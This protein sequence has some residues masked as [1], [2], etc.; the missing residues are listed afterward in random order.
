MSVWYDARQC[1]FISMAGYF[2]DFALKVRPTADSLNSIADTADFFVSVPAVK[3]YTDKAK[4][5]A[6]VTPPPSTGTITMLFLNKT[7]NIPQDSLTSYPDSL[8]LRVIAAGNV[9]AGNYTVRVTGNGSNGTPVHIRDIS[10]FL[11]PLIGITNI[12]NEVPSEFYLYQ[13]F[14]NPFNP[15]TN[16]R[17]DIAKSG[18]VKLKVYD[19]TGRQVSELLNKEF[20]A[21]KYMFDFDA[22][23]L[24]S[25]VYFYRLETP[26]F[27]DIKKMILVK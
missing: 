4:F 1:N 25:G 3:L 7:S 6:V 17:F 5:T 2:P 12:S 11:N 9:T 8:R 23:H 19:I 18:I 13:N 26:D 14:P 16:I 20:T 24:A 10:L 22:S 15:K 27:A 21:G